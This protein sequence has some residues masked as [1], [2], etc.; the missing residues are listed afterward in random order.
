[1]ILEVSRNLNRHS[2]QPGNY[3]A[4]ACGVFSSAYLDIWCQRIGIKKKIV[5]LSFIYPLLVN[6]HAYIIQ[7]YI[8]DIFLFIRG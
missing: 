5:A 4:I 6:R 2:D 8:L 7:Y 3:S 1:M